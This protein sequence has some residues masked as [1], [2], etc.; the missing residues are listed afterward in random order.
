MRQFLNCLFK[1]HKSDTHL[2]QD[3]HGKTCLVQSRSLR[4]LLASLYQRKYLAQN[5]DKVR[6]A[7]LWS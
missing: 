6:G 7:F 1:Y 3:F 4:A 5:Q 2:H